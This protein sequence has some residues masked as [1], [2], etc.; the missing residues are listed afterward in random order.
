MMSPPFSARPP[1][2]VETIPPA[3][4]MIGISGDDIVGLQAGIHDEVD[5]AGRHHGEG[6]AIGAVAGETHRRLE[7][8]VALPP[9]VARNSAGVVVN[10]VASASAG[11]LRIDRERGPAAGLRSGSRRRR[12]RTARR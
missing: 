9:L 2:Q 8:L 11:V 12:R 6:V 10:S 4:S 5:M 1:S 3:F 7:P